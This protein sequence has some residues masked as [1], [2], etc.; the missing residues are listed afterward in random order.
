[1]IDNNIDNIDDVGEDQYRV[2]VSKVEKALIDYYADTASIKVVEAKKNNGIILMGVS[3][4]YKDTNIA[5]TIYL[6]SF[7][8]EY[9]KGETLG[10][11]VRRII[12]IS[13]RHTGIKSVDISFFME[14]DTVKEYLAY[15][16]VNAEK[17][18]ELLKE[19]PHVDY[20]DMAIIFYCQIDM[21][22]YD[23]SKGYCDEMGCI[24]IYNSHLEMWGKTV[25][26]IYEQAKENTPKILEPEWICMDD[27]LVDMIKKDMKRNQTD[28]GN[29]SELEI[30]AKQLLSVLLNGRD[31]SMFV[32]SNKQRRYGATVMLYKD[33]LKSFSIKSQHNIYI[34]PSS[35]H[36][37]IV[38]PDAGLERTEDLKSMVYQVNR[39]ELAY[40]DILS[41]SVYKY[42]LELDEVIML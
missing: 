32:L 31:T 37:L 21:G 7:Y 11:I 25:E 41:D 10:N 29:E 20:L 16:L 12:D 39:T 8:D 18:R 13:D 27:L 40:E 38:I 26:D 36:E 30:A 34:I 9:N 23:L 14:Y 5:P 42:D 19:V 1:M 33:V 4:L 17:N 6:E 15:R 3:V 28:G 35:I 24:T 22:Q 2:F